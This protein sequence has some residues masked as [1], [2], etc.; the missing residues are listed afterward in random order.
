MIAMTLAQVAACVGGQVE[1]AHADVVVDAPATVDSREVPAGGLFVALPGARVDGHDFAQA[2]VE[3]GAAGVLCSRPLGDLPC[4]V[5]PDAVRALGLLAQHVH[6]RLTGCTTIAITGSQGKTGTKDMLA[7]ITERA[8]AT[9]SPRGNLNNEIGVPLTVLHADEHTRFLVVEMG[10]R[11]IGHIRYL[12]DLVRPDVAVVLNVG[13][14]HV[15]IFGSRADIATAKQELVEALPEDGLAVLN[16]DD[17]LVRAMAKATSARAVLFGTGPDAGVRAADLVVDEV[18]RPGFTLGAP[19]QDPAAIRLGMV[20]EHQALNAA[21]AAAAA[22]AAGVEWDD[23]L[24]GLR[25]AVPRSRWRMEVHER[26]D[27]VTVIND[28][29]NANPDSMRAA[30]KTLASLGAGGRRT[31]AVLGE[32][33]E[34]GDSAR[35][36]HEALGTLVVRLNIS[37]LVTVGAGAQPIHLAASLEGSWG[38]EAVFVPDADAAVAFLRDDLRPGDVVLLKASRA[39]GLE[40]V[41]DALLDDGADG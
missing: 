39:A 32:M 37:R 13:V 30:L 40:H 33:L 15:G 18:G 11:G 12:A 10:A 6:R 24:A 4:V 31:V 38:E 3:A 2:A 16:A 23:V 20:G 36:E 1:P 14:A 19:G 9:V 28:A 35:T 7:Q 41:A 26:D 25:A 8:G 21:A 22:L 34:L 27:G 29:Y 17:D 5:V